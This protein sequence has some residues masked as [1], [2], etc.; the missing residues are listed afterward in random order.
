[1]RLLI[2]GNSKVVLQTPSIYDQTA[3]LATEN[4]FGANDALKK[5]ADYLKKLAKKYKLPLVDYWTV[6]SAVNTK[7]QRSDPH[8][9]LIGLDRVHPGIEGHFLMA[10]EFLKTQ[11]APEY[12]SYISIDAEKHKIKKTLQYRIS[13]LRYGSSGI[14]FTCTETSLPYPL[15]SE[16]FNPDSLFSFTDNFN[17]EIFQLTSLQKGY[18][19]LSIDSIIVGTYSEKELGTGINLATNILT[20]QYSQSKKVVDHFDIYWDLERKLR[21]IKYVEYQHLRGMKQFNDMEKIKRVLASN[22]EGYKIT[23]KQYLDYYHECYDEYLKNK[24]MEKSMAMELARQLEEIMK[25]S[26]P[27]KHTYKVTRAE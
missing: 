5:C 13:E 26:K 23:Q 22:I 10:G 19:A 1:M 16:D 20:P 8:A 25:I 18:Y 3:D 14:S 2:K 17:K 24:P 15:L 9:T 6:M 27:V 7:V 4:N 12:V 21:G 11:Q